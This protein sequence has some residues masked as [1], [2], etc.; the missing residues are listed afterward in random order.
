MYKLIVKIKK[1]LRLLASYFYSFIMYGSFKYIKLG[2]NVNISYSAV[3]HIGEGCTVMDNS[4]I[5]GN[6]SL[7]R[8]VFIHENVLIRSFKYSI[9]IGEGTTINRNTCILANCTIGEHV[10]IAPNVVI[11]GS[12]HIYKDPSILIK[13]QELSSNG[14]IIE[15]DVWIG[16]NATILDG[17][18]VGKGAVIAAGA[19]VTKPIPDYAVVAG[20][21]ATIIK[22]R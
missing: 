17:V 5:V 13:K 15:D 2:I 10:S 16:A 14:I 12:N 1:G 11:V 9:S 18:T 22:Y 19:V 7:C 6:V 20:I 8:N 21:P 4:S 3:S